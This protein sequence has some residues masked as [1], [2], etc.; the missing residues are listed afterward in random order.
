MVNITLGIM[1]PPWA[2]AAHHR[3]DMWLSRFKDVDVNV[4]FVVGAGGGP[5][6]FADARVTHVWGRERLPHVGKV[7]E[8]SATWWMSP[9]DE[10]WRCKSDDDT[11]VHLKR[12]HA[13]LKGLDPDIASVSGYMKWRGWQVRELRACGGVWGNAGHVNAL[14]DAG[15][16]PNAS[17]PFPYMSGAFYCMSRAAR[18]MLS[19]DKEFNSFVGD[20][21]R[22]NLITP[23][24]SSASKCA[25]V[26]FERRAWHHEDAGIAFN[27][28]RAAAR[29]QTKLRVV[30]VPGHYNDPFSIETDESMQSVRWSSNAVFV[31][32]IKSRKLYN[33]AVERWKISRPSRLGSFEC[34][35]PDEFRYNW[36]TA[37]LPCSEHDSS[38]C[39]FDPRNLFDFC[40]W[41][42]V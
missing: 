15:A 38:L 27:L 2:K 5:P 42:W 17:G 4:R 25:S 18:T 1:I 16:C 24:C 37:R 21:S 33:K 13:Y 6:R 14:F 12:L 36:T 9:G 34:L 7:T 40:G 23:K 32:G 22:R 35:C 28:F 11:L 3:Q 26:T 30:R 19:N 41:E 39:R 8:K 31:H 29:S 10:D 20:A